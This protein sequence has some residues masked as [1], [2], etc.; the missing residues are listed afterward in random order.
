MNENTNSKKYWDDYVDYFENKCREAEN[1][2]SKDRTSGL[3]EMEFYL[4]LLNLGNGGNFLDYGCGFGR[5][6]PVYKS[7]VKSEKGYIGIDVSKRTLELAEKTYSDLQIGSNLFEYD[8]IS[9]PFD[10][11]YFQSVFCCG[12]FDVTVQEKALSEMLRVLNCNGKLYISGKNDTYN[13][14]DED[15]LIAEVNAR[16]KSFPNSFTDV[17]KL[18]EEIIGR[19]YILEKEMYYCY[20]RDYADNIFKEQIP[21]KFYQWAWVIEKGKETKK[22]LFDK[23]SSNYSKT[24]C[25]IDRKR[26]NK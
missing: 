19:G 25:E 17:K 10:D 22:E 7:I 3:E 11:N 12:V 24:F 26:E 4:K 16:R 20:R 6:F 21:E 2:T 13:E 1:N 18:R 9:I 23:F 15:A 5:V 14:D 8:G